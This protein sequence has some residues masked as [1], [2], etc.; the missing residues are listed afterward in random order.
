MLRRPVSR[1]AWL[2]VG[3]CALLIAMSVGLLVLADMMPEYQKL[4]VGLA[5]FVLGQVSYLLLKRIATQLAAEDQRRSDK[6]ARKHPPIG[7]S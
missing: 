3:E 4:A 6:H 1:F 7:P 5:S 2:L